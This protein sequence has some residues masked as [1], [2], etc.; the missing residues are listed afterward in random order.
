LTFRK[1]GE[2]SKRESRGEKR[3]KRGSSSWGFG[4]R[5][6]T[7]VRFQP[8]RLRKEKEKVRPEG[9]GKKKR[10]K[11]EKAKT[12]DAYLPLFTSLSLQVANV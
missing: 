4:I 1:E 2:N 9:G 8:S 3:R 6:T 7:P 5:N 11:G 10:R 12:P